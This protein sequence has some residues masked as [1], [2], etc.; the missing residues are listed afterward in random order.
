MSDETPRTVVLQVV[1]FYT[2]KNDFQILKGTIREASKPESIGR[3]LTCLGTL[4]DPQIGAC[5]RLTGVARKNEQYNEYQ[6]HFTEAELSQ[7]LFSSGFQTYLAKE[8][9]GIGPGRADQIVGTLGATL[10]VLTNQDLLVQRIVG[11]I[12]PIAEQ[13]ALWAESQCE[14]WE[15][16]SKLYGAGLT[17]HLIAKLLDKYHQDTERI[18]REE[19]FQI[20]EIK[21]IGF[22]TADRVAKL[23]GMQPNHPSRIRA[24]VVYA[25]ESIMQDQGH[26]CLMYHTL[27]N[28]ASKLLKLN[29]DDLIPVV[30]EMLKEDVFC[31][32]R[33]N[34]KE[35]VRDPNLLE[36]L[37]TISSTTTEKR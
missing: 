30:K 1:S 33:T 15:T 20:T 2:K 17:A 29:P 8:C 32:Q 19:C 25:M 11:I 12:P 24:G 4:A 31:T 37:C 3:K 9:D 13:I 28:E 5:Y 22:L 16:K 27:L 7:D 14:V 18:L 23:F 35:L 26:T 36:Y 10:E 21:G 6:L 34:P